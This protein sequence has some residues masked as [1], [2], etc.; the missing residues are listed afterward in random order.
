MAEL[1]LKRNEIEVLKVTIDDKNYSIPLGTSLRRKE[2]AKL[3]NEDEVMKFFENYLG[4]ELMDDLTIGEIKTIITAWSEAT[5]KQ[6]GVK[7]G[8]S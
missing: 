7:L 2:L 3:K 8:E 4:K 1:T 5:E 6:S